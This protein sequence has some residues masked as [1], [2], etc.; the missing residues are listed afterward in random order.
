MTKQSSRRIAA[1]GMLVGILVN[2]PVHADCGDKPKPQVD[3]TQCTK[4]R[5]VLR[6]NDLS[7]AVLQRTN[8]SSTDLAG[9]KLQGAVLVEAIIDRARLREADLTGADLTKAQGSR[10]N[11]QKA[12]LAGATLKK[13]ELLRADFSGANLENADLSKAE[14]GRAVFVEAN[15]NGADLSYSN[16][17]RANFSE[18]QLENVDLTRTY[19]YLTRME[20]VDLS[21]T[22][23][24]TQEQLELACGDSHTQLPN[25]LEKPTSWPCA[26]DD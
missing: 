14:L 3:W 9:A 18:A 12:N 2:V 26:K 25:G 20:G 19:T 10:V 22:I 13:S 16:I 15:L 5:L 17:A 11:F 4:M 21:K 1:L 8:L 23:G 6:N 24:L 7:G